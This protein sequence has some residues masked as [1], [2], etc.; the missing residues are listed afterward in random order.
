MTALPPAQAKSW[1]DD[2]VFRDD[3]P[4]LAA[5]PDGIYM[6]PRKRLETRGPK[7][8]MCRVASLWRQLAL[9]G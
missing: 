5:S 4:L 2:D 9:S 3:A 8:A 1:D 6:L 7:G